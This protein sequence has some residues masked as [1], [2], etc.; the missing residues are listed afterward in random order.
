M[1]ATLGEGKNAAAETPTL[2]ELL[3][4]KL[5]ESR[6]PFQ[7]LCDPG[8]KKEIEE[9]RE[10]V[11]Y[12]RTLPDT[13]RICIKTLSAEGKEETICVDWKVYRSLRAFDDLFWAYWREC[14]EQWKETDREKP[15]AR[16]TEEERALLATLARDEGKWKKRGQSVLESWKRHG[17]PPANF[18]ALAKLRKKRNNRMA[19]FTKKPK[20]KPK[21]APVNGRAGRPKRREQGAEA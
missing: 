16:C 11:T 20:R 18:L 5:R 12:K 1:K 15:P 8:R 7:K 6:V 21:R 13:E 2:E 10:G 14:G 9:T 4:S 19:N 3:D 17:V